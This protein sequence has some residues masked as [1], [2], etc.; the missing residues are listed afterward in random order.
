[1]LKF[2]STEGFVYDGG[3]LALYIKA[4]SSGTAY[5]WM[6]IQKATNATANNAK[7]LMRTGTYESQFEGQTWSSSTSGINIAAMTVGIATGDGGGTIPTI[8]ST[9]SGRVVASTSSMTYIEGATVT[10]TETPAEGEAQTYTAET[11]K[12]G[13]YSLTVDPV[14]TKATYTLK[15]EKEGYET[16]NYPGAIDLKGG[17]VA[18]SDIAL[19]KLPVPATIKGTVKNSVT[20]AAVS[21][22]TVSFNGT[23]VTS[24]TE[25]NYSIAVDN[26]EALTAMTLTASASGYLPYS[27]NLTGLVGGDN[28]IDI[29]INPIPELPGEGT[30]IGSFN[31][32]NNYSYYA[33]I[34]PLTKYTASET[35]Y[36][37][38]MFEGVETGTKFSSISFYGYYA[39]AVATPDPD[40]GDDDYND[41]WFGMKRKAD[42]TLYREYEI[43]AYMVNTDQAT[44]SPTTAIDYSNLTPIYEGTVQWPM[45]G[46]KNA[47][48][49]TFTIPFETPFTYEGGNVAFLIES[50]NTVKPSADQDGGTV[51]YFCVDPNYS[52][53]VIYKES[54]QENG[55]IAGEWKVPS[56]VGNPNGVP[57]IK[58]GDYV[59]SGTVSGT[60]TDMATGEALEGVE[61]TLEAEGIESVAGTTDADGFYSLTL[62]QVDYDIDYTL[63][64]SY[65]DYYD[66]TVD[67]TFT[68]STL[69]QTI[70]VQ[71][72]KPV[73][74]L[75][76]K[77]IGSVTDSESSPIEGVTVTLSVTPADS[78]ETEGNIATTTTAYDGNFTI[79]VTELDLTATYTLSFSMEGYEPASSPAVFEYDDWTHGYVAYVYVELEEKDTS[80]VSVIGADFNGAIYTVTGICINRNATIEDVKALPQGIYIIEGKKVVIKD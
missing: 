72:E 28:N 27:M 70:D 49:L 67:V 45:L 57:V 2:E 47:P 54:S 9:V 33:P 34:Y 21:G 10:I 79:D 62:R 73:E 18:L 80:A 43:K 61:V 74:I 1:M 30:Q 7:L 14:D 5:Y 12:N 44:L 24:G 32:I 68:A 37:A 63:S 75:T 17:N 19:V 51:P 36:P 3:N 76:G 23:T 31:D 50:I 38:A 13:T 77:I 71:M 78:E 64:F 39:K 59:A 53:N 11:A 4:T 52:N 40:E 56:S 58:L 6:Y 65:G 25:G 48:V 26:I 60:V 66:E 29:N 42:D 46:S 15:V 22:A 16:Y 20:N 41:P 35:V 8:S 55:F 69:E